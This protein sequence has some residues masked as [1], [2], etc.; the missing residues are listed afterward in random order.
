MVFAGGVALR[1]GDFCDGVRRATDC[2]ERATSDE[3]DAGAS[4]S[5]YAGADESAG[6]FL[7]C[8]RGVETA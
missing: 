6:S 2:G 5:T 8:G 7:A 4:A 1:R 3:Y